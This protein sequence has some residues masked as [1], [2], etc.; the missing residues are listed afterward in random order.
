MYNILKMSKNRFLQVFPQ[1]FK[2]QNL[3]DQSKSQNDHFNG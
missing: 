2:K 1:L 3:T